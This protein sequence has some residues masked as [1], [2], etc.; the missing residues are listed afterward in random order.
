MRIDRR[1][2]YEQ[3]QRERIKANIKAHLG[4]NYPPPTSVRQFKAL[5]PLAK[6]GAALSALWL[7]LV[8][9]G[10]T[11]PANIKRAVGT[12]GTVGTDDVGTVG[13]D[14]VGT[15]DV[16][17][18]GTDD[19]GGSNHKEMSP[20][21]AQGVA[22]GVITDAGLPA[23][24]SKGRD[25]PREL[26]LDAALSVMSNWKGLLD[27][28]KSIDDPHEKLRAYRTL[29]DL[30]EVLKNFGYD[31]SPQELNVM[32]GR[33]GVAIDRLLASQRPEATT[34]SQ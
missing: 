17:T 10:D 1:K 34:P 3:R 23:D 4:A 20:T 32:V 33:I 15:D 13:T 2:A 14:D 26:R 11:T 16:G 30:V 22:Q 28:A 27:W 24:V 12:V 8:E 18:V 6:D 5:W 21:V 19:V 29:K 7:K 9:S 25:L 31:N